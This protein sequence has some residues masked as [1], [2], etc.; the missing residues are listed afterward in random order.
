LTDRCVD[1]RRHAGEILS[2]LQTAA[3]QE[4]VGVLV[5]TQHYLRT[6]APHSRAGVC[7]TAEAAAAESTSTACPK[8]RG[9]VEVDRERRL[10]VAVENGTGALHR[11]RTENR[12]TCH[13]VVR[14]GLL[15]TGVEAQVYRKHGTVTSGD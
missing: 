1:N 4:R 3:H 10:V 11:L 8:Q 2:V 14:L 7:A 5:E 13:Q 9:L 12:T 6:C 15:N